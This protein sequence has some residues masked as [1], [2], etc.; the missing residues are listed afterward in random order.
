MKADPSTPDPG[1]PDPAVRG[2]Y[3]IPPASADPDLPDPDLGR[4]PGDRSTLYRAAVLAV[5]MHLVV[6]VLI[7]APPIHDD[8]PFVPMAFIDL[9]YD[10][11]GGNPGGDGFETAG[12]DPP[13]MEEPAPPEP[14]PEPEPEE[15]EYFEED[16]DELEI[17]ESVSEKAVEAPPPP[18]PPD[19]EV[20]RPKPQPR[21]RPQPAAPAAAATR[22]AGTGGA[23]GPGGGG[24]P[25]T[26]Q[27]GYGGGTGRGVADAL[28]A[29]KS[30]VR[31]KIIRYRKYPPAARNG[32]IEGTVRV[33]F[34]LNRQG[35]VVSFRMIGSSGHAIL[36]DEA[37]A[38]IR[39]VNPLPAFPKELTMS[40]LEL[41]LPIQ[42]TL[43]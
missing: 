17:L 33:S 43:Q 42:F 12:L 41:T 3:P 16:E 7:I 4:W 13:P 14:E 18:P 37:A 19:P 31:G 1:F 11:L 36:D 15:A 22:G 24:G 39:R 26:G 21:P 5:A 28:A 9:D 35:E 27:G 25:G 40:T 20:E 10:P 23:P 2:D 29:Y 30:R 8:P 6:L 34:T 32:R 38:L